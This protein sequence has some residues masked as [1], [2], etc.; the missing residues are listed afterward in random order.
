[1]TD[2]SCDE[3]LSQ[4]RGMD[5]PTIDQLHDLITRTSIDQIYTSLPSKVTILYS[6]P[7]A[8]NFHANGDP[9]KAGD[10]AEVMAKADLSLKIINN[11]QVGK[12]LTNSEFADKMM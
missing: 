1:M 11:T 12:L 7:L 3:V 4:L 6:G 5:N 9:L 2:I 10:V 8:S